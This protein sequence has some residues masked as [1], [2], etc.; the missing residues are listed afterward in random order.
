[1]FGDVGV[2]VFAFAGCGGLVVCLVGCQSACV[3]EDDVA[4]MMTYLPNLA[5]N[6]L[7]GVPPIINL[8][9]GVDATVNLSWLGEGHA[10]KWV[11][12]PV[13]PVEPI[14]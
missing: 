2:V 1:M 4:G 3:G 9:I 8:P 6:R 12:G 13:E 14:N 5:P 11:V 10:S 7:A